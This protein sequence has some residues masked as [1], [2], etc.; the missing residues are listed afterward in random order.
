MAEMTSIGQHVIRVDDK[1]L[2][3]ILKGLGALLS[4]DTVQV[5]GSE[6][7][8]IATLNTQLL[9]SALGKLEERVQQTGQKL[10]RAREFEEAVKEDAKVVKE[11]IG[12]LGR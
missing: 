8:A 9:N 4:P 6:R 5:R 1:E 12:G 2:N 3:L 11:T 10:D 7:Q